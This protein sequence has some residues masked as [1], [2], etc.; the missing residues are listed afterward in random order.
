MHINTALTGSMHISCTFVH[1]Y[2][3]Q[4]GEE[5]ERGGLS[6]GG[7]ERWMVWGIN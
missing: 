1:S 7:K 4:R 6:K 2:K 3:E 5:E